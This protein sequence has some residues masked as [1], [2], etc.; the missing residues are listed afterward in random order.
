[1]ISYANHKHSDYALTKAVLRLG[2]N[3]V[4][5]V[6]ANIDQF[7]IRLRNAD[8]CQNILI[9]ESFSLKYRH[10]LLPFQSNVCTL[11]RRGGPVL[12]R[13]WKHWYLKCGVSGQD[14]PFRVTG[15]CC[16]RISCFSV[17]HDW[18]SA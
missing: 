12:F 15:A 2:V 1:M 13:K 18:S 9:F 8:Y 17:Y 11:E 6:D 16:R 5:D 4:L 14:S 3:L 10:L 7:T